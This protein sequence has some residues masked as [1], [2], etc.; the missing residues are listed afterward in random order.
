MMAAALTALALAVQTNTAT[1]AVAYD[2]EAL[3]LAGLS[4]QDDWT[5]VPGYADGVVTTAGSPNGTK[6]GAKGTGAVG[7][8]RLNN[9]NWSYTVNPLDTDFYIQYDLRWGGG[10]YFSTG[11]DA[12]GSYIDWDAAKMSGFL[13]ANGST[14]L[15]KP[16]VFSGFY[17]TSDTLA[18][19]P[20]ANDWVRLQ[21][22]IDW[23]A[24][25]YG[26]M[27]VNMM[28]LTNG[29]TSYTPVSFASDFTIDLGVTWGS[30]KNNA[31][32]DPGNAGIVLLELGGSGVSQ[33]DN[34][35]VGDIPEPASL[36]LLAAGGVVMLR[37]RKS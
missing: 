29:E 17:Y 22:I 19:V 12:A 34:I 15:V 21:Y 16:D 14:I 5:T 24:S 13:V 1:A 11:Y 27:S 20:N 18:A 25:T 36:A 3:N 7:V 23:T 6:V 8:S 10:G 33:I 31:A 30:W 4:G 28:N 2:F 26:T 9:A 32:A 35:F 37:R